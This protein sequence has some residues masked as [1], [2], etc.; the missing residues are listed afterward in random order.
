MTIFF[1][2]LGCCLAGIIGA[3]SSLKATGGGSAIWPFLGG[4]AALVVWA[5]M[6]KQD[7]RPWVAAVLFDGTYNLTWLVVL[8]IAGER[9]E[10]RQLVGGLLVLFGL[11]LCAT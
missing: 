2:I 7:L 10:L 9:P 6:T 8:L 3:L 5:W 11:I 1:S 4:Q